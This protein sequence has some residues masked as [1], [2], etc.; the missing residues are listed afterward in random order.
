MK[1]AYMKPVVKRYGPVQ[2]FTG[3]TYYYYYGGGGGS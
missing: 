2:K 1:K 3:Y